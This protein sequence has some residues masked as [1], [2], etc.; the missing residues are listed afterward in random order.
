MDMS[1]NAVE[2]IEGAA[3]KDTVK[4]ISLMPYM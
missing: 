2:F 4:T 3:T 1:V